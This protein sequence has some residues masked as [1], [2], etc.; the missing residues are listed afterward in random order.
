MIKKIVD[1][2]KILEVGGGKGLLGAILKS[3]GIEI[4]VTEPFYEHGNYYLPI[5]KLNSLDAIKK[6]NDYECLLIAWP[7]FEGYFYKDSYDNF[8]G[9]MIIIIGEDDG[10]ATDSGYLRDID[11]WDDW[12]LLKQIHHQYFFHFYDS[13]KIYQRIY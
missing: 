1:H 9:D 12:I 3:A 2:R 8:K 7:S 4:K 10:G 6:Y 11:D 5:E 13:I